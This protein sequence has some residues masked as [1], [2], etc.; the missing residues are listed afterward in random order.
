M[1]AA[2][3]VFSMAEST[4]TNDKC[5]CSQSHQP[6]SSDA[7]QPVRSDSCQPVNSETDDTWR[8]LNASELERQC[9]PSRWSHQPVSSETVLK[10]FV[11]H[12][13]QLSELARKSIAHRLSVLCPQL[14]VFENTSSSTDGAN[15]KY[16]SPSHR[17]DNSRKENDGLETTN[18]EN[19]PD[20][21]VKRTTE[22]I[23]TYDNKK[24]MTCRFRN[25]DEFHEQNKYPNT[26]TDTDSGDVNLEE[27]CC[28]L[29]QT[30]A[31][32]LS[33]DTP[34]WDEYGNE[35]L[36]STKYLIVFVHGGY[37]Q[38]MSSRIA[39]A[40]A[41]SF[42]NGISSSVTGLNTPMYYIA[43]N[44]PL[45]PR[46]TL[47]RIER[48]VHHVAHHL[49]ALVARSHQH[50]VLIGHSAG[51][52]LVA[53]ILTEWYQC[54]QRYQVREEKSPWKPVVNAVYI[55]GV[56]NLGPLVNTTVNEALK[57]TSDTARR[58][59]IHNNQIYAACK[60]CVNQLVMVGEHESPEFLRQSQRFAARLQHNRVPAHTVNSLVMAGHDHFTICQALADSESDVFLEI[61]Q[62]IT[63]P[64]HTDT[65]QT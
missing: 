55:S 50:V 28:R 64:V 44:Y 33:L 25:S 42:A 37:W 35:P 13:Q 46:V 49:A 9:Q 45:A 59:S 1:S 62:L 40:P 47:C 32:N 23:N 20:T 2:N 60:M 51:A 52:H 57:L 61:E 11:D 8:A 65:F 15:Q 29:E 63:R 3:T 7:C 27:G 19:S 43:V 36:T 14:D 12:C 39:A 54:W 24:S 4:S 22:T 38:E 26:T 18:V 48:H 34:L 31:L 10:R 56:Y 16:R 41:L 53:C 30:T 58:H 21:L 6:V 5:E 17:C